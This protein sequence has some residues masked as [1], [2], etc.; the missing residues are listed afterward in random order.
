[1]TNSGRARD[2][3]RDA[4]QR[5]VFEKA[6]V[7]GELVRLDDAWREV[8]RRREYPPAVREVLGDLMAACA[9]MAA[10][11]K[12]QGGELV[13]Q[14]QGGGPLRLLVVECRADLTMRATAR[15]DEDL[16]GLE[17]RAT[18]RALT[19]GGHCAITIDP[20]PGLQA[21]QGVVPLHGAT[22]ADALE[23]YMTR[24]EQVETRFW[25]AADGERA[26]GLLLQ[27]L[28]DH[29]GRATAQD[30]EDLWDR[31]NALGHTVTREELLTLPGRE[32]LRRLFHE[33]DLRLFE[34]LSVRF[35]CRC[36]RD[37]VAGVI[38]MIGREEAEALLAERGAIEVA[39]EFCA[40]RYT[41]DAA[42]TASALA[43]RT[44]ATPPS[45]G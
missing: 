24:S 18:L 13:L 6:R 39:C 11:L 9:L 30:D 25:L 7:R 19:R 34:S 41:F 23:E 5:F 8:L 35:A 20:G 42:Q 15:F 38:R 21:Y 28:P 37:T 32:I 16:A 10:T 14:I 27:R 45:A 36:S 2:G 40:L 29:G 4:L 12:F 31:V 26:A 43:D 44:A 3:E 22:A 17:E 1:M 33:E